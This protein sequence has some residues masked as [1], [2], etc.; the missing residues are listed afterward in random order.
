VGLFQSSKT[1]AAKA[2]FFLFVSGSAQRQ[3]LYL[4]PLYLA[5]KY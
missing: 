2:A 5:K 1:K 4:V 3:R